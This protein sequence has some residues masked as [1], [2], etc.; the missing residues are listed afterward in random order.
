MGGG[1]K[2]EV[3]RQ[4]PETTTERRSSGPSSAAEEGEKLFFVSQEREKKHLGDER[5]KKQGD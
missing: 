5:G 3:P 2:G 4:L 1:R